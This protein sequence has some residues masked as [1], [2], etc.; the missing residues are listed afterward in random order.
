MKTARNVL[1]GFLIGLAAGFIPS[2]MSLREVRAELDE[3]RPKAAVSDVH[4]KL[5]VLLARVDGGEWGPAAAASTAA[6]DA[7]NRLAESTEDP[8]LKRRLL[9]ASQSRDEITAAIAAGDPIV[10]GDVRRLVLLL[11]ESL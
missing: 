5:S 2:Y 7:V 3:L 8:D 6:F 4:S 1:I 10:E 11:A 9:T